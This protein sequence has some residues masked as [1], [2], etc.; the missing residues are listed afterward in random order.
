MRVVVFFLYMCFHLL[1]GGSYL[2]AATHQSRICISSSSYL[3]K[4]HQI[5]FKIADQGNTI[6]EDVD[7]DLDEE[8]HCGDDVSD[9]TPA[10]FFSENGS[11]LNRWY[12][13][14]SQR[15]HLN[16]YRKRYKI[17]SSFFGYSNPIYITQRVLRL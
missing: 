3:A 12:L 8:Y 1:G 9:R 2:H 11:L 10:K 4:N 6:I 16:Y 15:F 5:K 17:F 13:P 7:L 14:I